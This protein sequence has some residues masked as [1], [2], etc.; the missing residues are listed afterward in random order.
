MTQFIPQRL[1]VTGGAGFIGSNFVHYWTS[2]YPQTPVWVLDAL[3]YAGNLNNIHTLIE[4]HQISFI[5]GDINNPVLI[6]D[7][8]NQHQIDTIIHF[9]AESHVNRSILGPGAFVNTNVLGTFNLLE[10][11]RQ[12]WIGQGKPDHLR[13]LHISTDEVFG[14]LAPHEPS[15]SETT[16]YAPNSP[17]SASKAGSD[18]LVRSYFH[19]YGLPTLITNC[20]N[21][22]GPYHFPE[23]LIPLM[24]VNIL[25]GQTLPVYGDGL[26]VRDWLFVEDHCRA[27]DVVLHHAPAGETFNIG[28]NCEITNIDLITTLCRLMDEL[29]LNL[30]VAPSHR[31]ITF[32]TDRPGHDRRYGMDTTKIKTQLG[33]L[34]SVSLEEGLR[35]TVSWYLNHSDWW[36][37]L[38]SDDYRRYYHQVYGT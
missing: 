26:N 20:S 35:K 32:V 29:A 1:L 16:A 7:L 12:Y 24:C 8:L 15:F 23:K 27:I 38:L 22:Y 17:Y 31:L 4:N 30:P 5:Q 2:H 11:F 13:F 18:H 19:T 6:N 37:P 28:G 21:N 34:P 33:W 3:T 25:L 36:M 14:S 10:T 9:A